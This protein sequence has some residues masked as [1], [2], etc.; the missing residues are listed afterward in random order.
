MKRI[1]IKEIYKSPE[2][3]AYEDA[4]E[5]TVAGWARSVRSSNTVGFIEL[6]DGSFFKNLQVVFESA[7]INNYSEIS[8]QNVGASFAVTGKII[9]TPDSKQ[10]F[11]MNAVKIEVE[12]T[13]TPEYPLQKKRHSP[14][15]LR[16]IAHLRPRTNLYSAVFRVRSVTA[17]AI[18]KFFN[19]RN[20]VYIHTPLIT[21]ADAEGAG[22]MFKVT[23]LDLDKLEKPVDYTKDFFGKEVY[24]TVTG[25]LNVE[26]FAMTY[27]N[28]YTF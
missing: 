25:Q 15:F 10:T 23:T 4:G 3:F 5:I 28:V 12:G 19:E 1:Q 20:F 22:D 26:C 9:L 27:G 21:T 18:H 13:S 2:K 17:Y 16:E 24:L 14:E 8:S 6:N 11:E 7:N